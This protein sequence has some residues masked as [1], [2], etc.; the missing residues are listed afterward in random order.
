[1]WVN[2]N[3][4]DNEVQKPHMFL[5]REIGRVHAVIKDVNPGDLAEA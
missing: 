2:I 5:P 3:N 1:M 4:S